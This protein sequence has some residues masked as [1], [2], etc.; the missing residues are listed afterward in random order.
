MLI[1]VPLEAAAGQPRLA[2][3]PTWRAV[4]AQDKDKLTTPAD[5]GSGTALMMMAA[6]IDLRRFPMP[7]T[8]AGAR[9]SAPNT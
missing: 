8:A 6:D 7:A 3:A 2:L 5:I 4:C 9:A 1:G